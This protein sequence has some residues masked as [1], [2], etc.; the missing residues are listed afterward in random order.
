MSSASTRTRWTGQIRGEI[1][2]AIRSGVSIESACAGAG[3]TSRQFRNWRRI[4]FTDRA[5]GR[6]TTYARFVDDVER[7]ELAAIGQVEMNIFAQSAEDWR[8]G[9]FILAKKNPAKYGRLSEDNTVKE[10]LKKKAVLELMEF[11][12]ARLPSGAYRT[13]LETLATHGDADLDPKALPCP[14]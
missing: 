1:V 12:E 6:N 4:G 13:V 2:G 9:A 11:L 10:E 3:V 5:E 14:G 8:A 7:A